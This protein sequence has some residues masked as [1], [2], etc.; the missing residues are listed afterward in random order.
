VNVEPNRESARREDAAD[1]LRGFRDRFAQPHSTSGDLVYLCTHSLGLQ[2]LSARDRVLEELDDWARLAVLGHTAAR[3][4]WIDY[5]EAFN[6]MLAELVGAG[7]FEVVAMNSLTINL[8]LMMASFYR[9]VPGRSRILIEAGAFSSD[10]HAVA[11][12][13]EWHGLKPGEIL[14]EL[15]PAAGSDLFDE[16]EI[17]AFL[18]ERGGEI[19]LV[20]WPGVQYRTGQAFELARIARAARRAGALVG[21]DLAHSIGNVPLELHASGADF[22][23]WCSYKYL[24]A[25]PG[26]IGGCFVHERHGENLSTPRLAGW[27]GHDPASRFQ[28]LPGFQPM[29]GAGGWQVSNPPILSAAP[30]LASLEL[31]REARI[32]RL[33]DKSLKLCAFLDAALAR[34][35]DIQIV[36]PKAA[37]ARGSQISLR[38]GGA[39]GRG[40]TVFQHLTSAR[41]V[42]DWREPDVIRIAPAPL[43]N[44]FEDVLSFVE[45]LAKALKDTA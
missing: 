45:R 41:V 17:E 13:I 7:P 23:V 14:V 10:R 39:R 44:G 42:C 43:Y 1:P 12:Q 40:R 31:F 32:T 5:H 4:A 34:V 15:A 26:A 20:L 38:V 16:S 8:H 30:L 18:D 11:A 25:G 22:A 36:T 9:P 37:S 27:W 24:N 6:P 3:R 33:R 2:P 21:F 29:P 35:P 19:A 28:M